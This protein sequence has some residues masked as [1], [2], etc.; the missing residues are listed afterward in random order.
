MSTEKELSPNRI[1]LSTT[2]LN[3]HIKYANPDFCDIAGFTLAEMQDSPHNIVRHPDMPKEAFTDLW[4]NIQAGKSWMGPVKNKCK[5]GDYYWVNAFVTPIKDE[6]GNI[7]EYQSVRTHLD[8]AV[9]SRATST[10]Q[11]LRS[12]KVPQSV[13]KSTD[14]TQWIPLAIILQLL[15]S[16]FGFANSESGLWLTIPSLVVAAVGCGIYFVWKRKYNKVIAY[17]KSICDNPLMAYLYSGD[18]DITSLIQFALKKRTAEL[19]ALVGRVLDDS[20]VVRNIAK[21]SCDSGSSVEEVLD[22]QVNETTRIATA[23]LQMSTT[24]K[25]IADVVADASQSSQKGLQFST[26][27]QEIVSEAVLSNENLALQL[28]NVDEALGKLINGTQSIDGV[29]KEIKG[30]AGQTNLLALN[31][32]IEAARAG[33]QG[34]G[35]AVVADEVRTLAIRSQQ[36]TEEI[37]LLLN[38]LRN[39]SA[40]V[41]DAMATGTELSRKCVALSR[42]TGRSLENINNEVANITD[43][44]LQVSTAIKE[45]ALVS[46]T[47]SQNIEN[48]SDIAKLCKQTGQKSI[49]LNS[50]LLIRLNNQK[51]LVM[52][53]KE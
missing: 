7:T 41:I 12:G 48:I 53:F 27:G 42:E 49:E 11:K 23:I 38:E 24:V 45:H 33:E 4:S 1:L 25:G 31:A 39:E 17:A 32:A 35:F 16:L 9:K 30:I 44:N 28:E 21:E 43:T 8:D 52:Q 34:R 6:H 50:N 2:D 18:S 37:G 46:K 26:Q 51:S 19:G 36:S 14:L 47:I 22:E 3:S 15:L 40:I 13:K 20:E 5:D 29:L 10:Y